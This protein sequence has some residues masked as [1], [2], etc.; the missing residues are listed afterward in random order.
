MIEEM[1]VE[2][3]VDLNAAFKASLRRAL[4]T[5]QPGGTSAQ[6]VVDLAHA[7]KPTAA[8]LGCSQLSLCCQHIDGL[9]S[10][11]DISRA[12]DHRIELLSKIE[13]TLVLV[14]RLADYLKTT[15]RIG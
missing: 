7:L 9:R 14:E 15:S 5:A 4:I 13:M 2:L 11:G 10:S 1:G 6:Q 8:M 3:V 12:I